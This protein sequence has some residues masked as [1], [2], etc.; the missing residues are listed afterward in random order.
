MTNGGPASVMVRGLTW[1]PL[2]ARTPVLEDLDLTLEPGERVLLTGPSGGGKSTL[3]RALAGVLDAAETGEATGEVRVA[4]REPLGGGAALLLQ[5]P[6]A[7]QVAETV[8]RDIAFGLENRAVPR[9]AIWPRVRTLIGRVGLPVA[10][11]HRVGALSGGESQRVGLAGTLAGADGLL[12]LDEPTSM[13][14]PDA[15]ARVRDCVADAVAGRAL[16][17]VVAEHRLDGWLPLVDRLVVVAGGRVVV[18]VP[19]REGRLG[20][21]EEQPPSG[22]GHPPE[23]PRYGPAWPSSGPASRWRPSLGEGPADLLRRLA[24]WGVWVP[25]APPPALWPVDADLCV[26]HGGTPSPSTM[27][28]AAAQAGSLP[29][30]VPLLRVADVALA[31]ANRGRGRETVVSCRVDAEFAAGQVHAVVGRSGVGKSTLLA[32]LAGLRRPVGGV[33]EALPPLAR[34]AAA[35]PHRWTSRQVAARVGY[36]PQRP[37]LSVIGGTCRAS[38]LATARALGRD[39][40]RRADA[41]AEQLGLGP[42][43]H[44]SPYRLSGGEARRLALA[45]A[46]VHGPDLLLL[47]EPTVGQDRDAWAAVAGVIEAAAQA[48]VAVVAATHDDLLADLAVRRIV[49]TRGADA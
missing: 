47:D 9:A 31:L 21:E 5:D 18:D 39:A 15:A 13:L 27:Q 2:G 35:H 7:G 10:E 16:T 14:D 1:T 20:G 28:A 43:A 36:V 32:A 42:L 26:S 33:L 19:V 3:L 41:L 8:G 25:E 34:E 23:R 29:G 49:L 22:E 45:S 46:L 17:L 37:H 30:G 24:R 48:G 38:L 44:R 11:D 12:L 4:D 6:G 40:E